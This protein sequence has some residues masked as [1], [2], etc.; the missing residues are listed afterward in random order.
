MNHPNRK[1]KD[2]AL[3]SDVRAIRAMAGITQEVAR[4][5][6]YVGSR[7]WEGYESDRMMPRS[8]MELWCIALAV[9]TLDH[10]P[11]LAPGDW[12]LPWVR[13]DL[14]LFFQRT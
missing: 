6:I 5:L 11:Y 9:G 1:P 8:A 2:G 7:T 3:P 12:M 13:R 14:A 4:G 10:G